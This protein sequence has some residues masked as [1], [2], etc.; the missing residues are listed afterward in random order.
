MFFKEE[1]LDSEVYHN[2]TNAMVGTWYTIY[3]PIGQKSYLNL[4]FFLFFSTSVAFLS[5]L[6]GTN[7]YISAILF[8]GQKKID[9]LVPNSITTRV[10]FFLLPFS[11]YWCC[12]L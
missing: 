10:F 11:P 5:S 3:T 12:L 8:L 1:D 7:S 2:A 6:A 4:F 9:V